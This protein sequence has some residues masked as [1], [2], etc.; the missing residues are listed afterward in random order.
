MRSVSG[1]CGGHELVP[2][3][4]GGGR[5]CAKC[6]LIARTP[7]SLKSLAARPC[8]GEVL[9]GIH[10]SHHLRW[11]TGVTWCERCGFYMSRLPRALKLP[12]AGAPRTAAASNV[13]RRLRSGLP[14][15]T[16]MY[17]Q[18]AAADE[19]WSEG[20]EA[21]C[22]AGDAVQAP[23]WANLQADI[24]LWLGRLIKPLPRLPLVPQPK[25][26]GRQRQQLPAPYFL[27]RAQPVI[28]CTRMRYSRPRRAAV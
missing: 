26:S 17:L 28:Y 12:C 18:R 16:A 13:L 3:E 9:L 2:R 14:P 1:Q 21:L 22:I 20:V 19:A 24:L 10:Q 7:A 27:G 15:T 25:L 8:R 4:S 11:S 6:K 5:W 23:A